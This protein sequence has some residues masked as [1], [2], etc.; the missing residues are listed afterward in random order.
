[1]PSMTQTRADERFWFA[2]NL[3]LLGLVAVAILAAIGLG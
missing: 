2:A 3:A 1:M